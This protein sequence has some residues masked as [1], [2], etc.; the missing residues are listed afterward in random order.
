MFF[1]LINQK[2]FKSASETGTSNCH[3]LVLTLYNQTI[4]HG[5]YKILAEVKFLYEFDH[6]FV[7]GIFYKY[8]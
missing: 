2:I 7:K 8:L 3:R 5:N 1:L 4:E 6:E